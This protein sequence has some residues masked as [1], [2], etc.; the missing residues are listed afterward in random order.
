MKYKATFEKIEVSE[1]VIEFECDD[2]TT[3]SS[4]VQEH[5]KETATDDVKIRLLYPL[6]E[7]KGG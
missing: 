2:I 1:E 4:F 6:E 7:I 5:I 3:A